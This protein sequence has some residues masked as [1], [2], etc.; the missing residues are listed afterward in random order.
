M[1]RSP[2]TIGNFFL[3]PAWTENRLYRSDKKKEEVE[4]I[5]HP[6]FNAVQRMMNLIVHCFRTDM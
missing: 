1:K 5:L 6:E 2:I 3:K 4:K